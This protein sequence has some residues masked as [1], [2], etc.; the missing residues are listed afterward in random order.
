MVRGEESENKR[1]F[2]I[3]GFS[4]SVVFGSVDGLGIKEIEANRVPFQFSLFEKTGTKGHPFLLSDLAFENGFLYAD[5]V[6]GTGACDASEPTGSAVIRSRDVVGDKDKHLISESE[7][8]I[9]RHRCAGRE[10][11]VSL[12]Q[13]NFWR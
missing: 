13:R 4:D 6:V 1:I 7:V 12:G 3:E 9:L 5:T 10:P 11:G 2:E 8:H